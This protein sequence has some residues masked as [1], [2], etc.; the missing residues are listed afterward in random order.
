MP[1]KQQVKNAIKN[2]SSVPL[3]LVAHASVSRAAGY[4]S[5]IELPCAIQSR[6]NTTFCK[7]AK[8]DTTESE[9]PVSTYRSLNELF[10]RR[11]K[12]GK[13]T[14]AP[15]DCVCPTDGRLR[16]TGKITKGHVIEAKHQH[17]DIA[18]LV[19]TDEFN[20]LFNDGQFATIYLSPKNYHRIHAPVSGKI[21]HTTYVP[22]KLFPVN[23]IGLRIV[24]NLFIQNERLTTIIRTSKG[25]HVAVVKVGATCVGRISLSYDAFATNVQKCEAFSK[26]LPSPISIKSGEE[27]GVF[28][29]G[30]T[31]VVL[32]E[33][34][35]FELD[36]HLN[37]NT[38]V[39]MGEALA[40]EKQ[41]SS[42]DKKRH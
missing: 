7:L 18:T 38:A 19:G 31:V 20:D 11:L 34:D 15:I 27:I 36:P 37:H 6:V 40:S 12:P 17:Y 16:A 4:I 21:I 22:G 13:R 33:Q 30:S 23:Q 41:H 32:F 10:T 8:I 42:K 1:L 35:A 5:E 29:L 14:I 39:S 25:H 24:D 3:R 2:V 26:K 9:K 28:E